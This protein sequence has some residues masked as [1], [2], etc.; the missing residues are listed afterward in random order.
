VIRP[1]PIQEGAVSES[2]PATIFVR[3]PLSHMLL[4][5][6]ATALHYIAGG[7]GIILGY[8][9]LPGYVLGGL[10]LGFAFVQMYVLMPIMVCPS[11]VYYRMQGGLCT[12]GLNLV[13]R[14]LARQRDLD[15]FESRAQ[16]ILCHNNLYLASLAFPILAM[17]PALVIAFSPVVLGLLLAVIGLL[18]LRFFVIF[19]KTACVHCA[20]RKQCPNA[21]SMGLAE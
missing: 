2:A 15:Q 5:N 11:C 19:P 1:I 9:G 3:Y 13:S 10:Y 7:T 20:A 17:I 12:S 18:A 16:G 4:Y 8:A 14:R 21:R 6:G